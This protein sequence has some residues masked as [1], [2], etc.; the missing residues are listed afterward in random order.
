MIGAILLAT[1]AIAMVLVLTAY[2]F[3]LAADIKRFWVPQHELQRLHERCETLKEEVTELIGE[4][5]VHVTQIDKAV[6][7]LDAH[8]SR[9]Q[10]VEDKFVSM[11]RFMRDRFVEHE[12]LCN[13]IQGLVAAEA[14]QT[15]K[16]NDVFD[17][18]GVALE[19]LTGTNPINES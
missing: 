17:R 11:D 8:L 16:I 6:R 7:R 2:V 4:S 19:E 18:I 10:A 5:Q 9:I 3:G 14:E 1:G 12:S 13:W 15:G